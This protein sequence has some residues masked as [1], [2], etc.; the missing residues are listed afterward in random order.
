MTM[1]LRGWTAT[2]ASAQSLSVQ[3]PLVLILS[4]ADL[5]ASIL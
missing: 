3:S 4:A 1:D 5:F 2:V